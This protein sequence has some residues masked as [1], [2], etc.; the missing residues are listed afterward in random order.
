M[1]RVLNPQCGPAITVVVTLDGQP[2]PGV[3]ANGGQFT[4]SPVDRGTH[5]IQMTVKDPRKDAT[6]CSSAP[7]TFYVRQPSLQ[8]PTN[9]AVRPSLED[10]D[11]ALRRGSQRSR[12]RRGY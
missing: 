6:V 10:T 9:P 1:S 7:V 4:I 8:S 2:V 11:D 12:V 5:T 3:P